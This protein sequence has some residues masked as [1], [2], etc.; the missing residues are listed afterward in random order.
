MSKMQGLR[1]ISSEHV[2]W[3]K[4]FKCRIKLNINVFSMQVAFEN[5]EEILVKIKRS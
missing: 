5:Y 3:L 2:C 4:Y 1:N